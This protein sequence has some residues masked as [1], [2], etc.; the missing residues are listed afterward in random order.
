MLR[1]HTISRHLLIALTVAVSSMSS[2]A[3]QAQL[4]PVLGEIRYFGINYCPTGWTMPVGQT[5]DL[6]NPPRGNYQGLAALLRPPWGQQGRTNNLKLPNLMDVFPGGFQTTHAIGTT[7]GQSHVTVEP[8][9]METHT[10]FVMA[11]SG[12]AT[13]SSA[14]DAY[15]AGY[16]NSYRFA[17]GATPTVDMASGSITQT[18]TPGQTFSVQHPYTRLTPCMSVDGYFPSRDGP[19]AYVARLTGEIVILPYKLSDSI[20]SSCPDGMIEANG[21]YLNASDFAALYALTGGWWGTRSNGNE[22]AVPDL[23]GRVPVSHGTPVI[24]NHPMQFTFA[25]EGGAE[26]VSIPTHEHLHNLMV[27]LEVGDQ[28]DP[29]R[30]YL[31]DFERGRVFAGTNPNPSLSMNLDSVSSEGAG[32][33]L[34]VV[35]PTVALHFCVVTRGDWPQHP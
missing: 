20:Q 1:A 11:D 26:T 8:T 24:N 17:N 29:Q 18:G 12:D 22:F 31:A 25:G 14:Q 5:I 15:L 21:T 6:N 23:G 9:N 27:A 34:P 35:A 28:P 2:P 30:N 32:A 4:N 7:Y 33:P 13:Q 10:H 19:D 3:A 16:S